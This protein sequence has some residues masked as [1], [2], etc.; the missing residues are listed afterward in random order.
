MY[1][2]I[3]L[4]ERDTHVH[5]FLWRNLQTKKQPTEYFLSRVTFGDKPS[6]DMASY[7]MLKIAKETESEYPDAAVILRR[8]RHMDDLIHSCP[9]S[10]IAANRM[11]ALDKAL[12][13]G[14]FEIKE[15]YCSSQPERNEK[16]DSNPAKPL[17]PEGKVGKA[18]P[19]NMA[20]PATDIKLNGER[21]QIKTLGVGWNPQTD[22]VNFTVK[23]LQISGA[24]TKRSVLSKISQI[25][26]PL[27]LASAVTIK[28]RVALQDIWRSKQ[29][30]WDDPLP[31]EIQD[32]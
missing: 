9:T 28:A 26:H 7:V 17:M 32:L 12:A 6:P 24:F 14:S 2:Q 8:D 20:P 21:G 10:Q 15:W 29:F 22:T 4:P 18:T 25:Y 23:D 31:E 3:L 16:R 1:L 5:R 11:T 27:G 19:S 13:Q 30:G